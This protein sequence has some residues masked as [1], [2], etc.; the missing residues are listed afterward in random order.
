MKSNTFASESGHWYTKDGVPAYT[1]IGKNGKERPA[2]V[3]DARAMGLYPS[4]TTISRVAAAP[5]LERWKVNQAILAALTIPRI[6]GE[7]DDDLIARI[8]RD[9]QEQAKKRA[10]QGTAIH[11][12]IEKAIAG[13]YYPKEHD[14]FVKAVLAELESRWG[15]D[16]WSV[17]KSFGCILG[18]G[19]KVDLHKP[20]I[21]ADFKTKEF[22]PEETKLAWPEHAMQLGAYRHGLDMPDAECANIFISVSNPGLIYT[23]I[24]DEESLMIGF[25]KFKC[26]LEYWKLDKGMQ[27]KP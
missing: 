27:E 2:T 16:G 25:N 18:Y 15:R 24:W 5:G 9:G 7:S 11:G 26:L 22:G 20:N 8:H 21:V 1:L 10:E 13:G 3:R 6:V 23:H 17:E 19:G 14:V 4:V 12:S